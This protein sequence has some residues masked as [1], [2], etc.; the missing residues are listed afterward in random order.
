MG[1]EFTVVFFLTTVKLYPTPY[2]S[3]KNQDDPKQI[4]SPFLIMAIL[5]PKKSASSIKCVVKTTTLSYLYFSS[6][7]QINLLAEVSQPEVGSSK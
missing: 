1:Y 7:S 5:S 3:F 4:N 2:L 6:I